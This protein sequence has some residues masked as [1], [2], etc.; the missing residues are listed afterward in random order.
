MHPENY[1][2][3]IDHPSAMCS[4]EPTRLNIVATRR[5][6]LCDCSAL[7]AATLMSPAL[8]VAK[9]S[10]PLW[11]KRSLREIP[12]ADL[13][14][15]L[16][17][18]FLVQSESGRTIKV[19]LAAVRMQ[20]ERPL[21]PGRRPPADAGNEKF[22]LVFSGCR[23]EL[24]EQNTYPFEHPKLGRFDLFVVPVFTRNLAKIDYEVV[25]NRPR[26]HAFQAHT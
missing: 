18:P 10:A 25:V 3:T 1:E 5:K 23:G 14:R 9:S 20:K 26:N 24:L 17:T 6:F 11:K 8:G 7:M 16:N 21:K 4:T 13:A 22:S 19:T 15:Q 12:C 2:K